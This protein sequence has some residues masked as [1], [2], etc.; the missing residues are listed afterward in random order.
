MGQGGEPAGG[1]VLASAKNRPSLPA[2]VGASASPSRLAPEDR[3][4]ASLDDAGSVTAFRFPTTAAVSVRRATALQQDG[5][6]ESTNNG[7]NGFEPGGP[8][9]RRNA[10]ST[11][12]GMPLSRRHER[13]AIA[14]TGPN[15]ARFAPR[16]PTSVTNGS[17]ASMPLYARARKLRFCERHLCWSSPCDVRGIPC[18]ARPC[19]GYRV[20]EM[21][22]RCR[23]EG[24][25]QSNDLD[26][27]HLRNGPDRL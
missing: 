27:S 26:S 20:G 22:R 5:G 18:D 16:D 2:D 25:V 19:R 24:R 23:I 13:C 1:Q 6:S 15:G 8:P 9:I 4:G 7:R 21:G 10:A 12:A 14:G 11:A 17:A 3:E